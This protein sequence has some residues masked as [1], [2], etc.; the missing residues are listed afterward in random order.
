V[1][2]AWLPR[3]KSQRSRGSERDAGCERRRGMS[4]AERVAMPPEVKRAVEMVMIWMAF[5]IVGR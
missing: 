3:L 5:D 2:A 4:K 1:G